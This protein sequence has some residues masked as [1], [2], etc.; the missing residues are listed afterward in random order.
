MFEKK[1]PITK[2]EAEGLKTTFRTPRF[3]IQPIIHKQS[4]GG[5]PVI[6]N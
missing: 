3:Y 2:H 6:N 1:N 5:R 4:N